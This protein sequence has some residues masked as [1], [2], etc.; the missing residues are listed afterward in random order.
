MPSMIQHASVDAYIAA[1]PE[2]QQAV[3]QQ[4]RK[5]IKQAAPKAE[6]VISYSMPAI[7]QD[8]IVVWYAAAQKHY[9]LYPKPDA[10]QV[11]KTELTGYD[12]AKGTIRF[13]LDKPLPLSLIKSIVKYR[14]TENKV[15]AARKKEKKKPTAKKAKPSI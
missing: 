2:K 13:P 14:L 3:L 7:K 6:E 1:Q 10:I 11:F 4:I 5:A 15:L 12:T 8:G 9:A